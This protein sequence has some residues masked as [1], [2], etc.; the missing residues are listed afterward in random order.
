MSIKSQNMKEFIGTKGRISLVLQEM[1]SG[2]REEG[3]LIT[4]YNSEKGEYK[5]INNDSQYKDMYG[6][7]CT[8]IDMIEND[9]EG[10]P[11]I[12]SVFS[13]FKI[14]CL[15]QQGIMENRIIKID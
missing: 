11:T 13:A 14:A 7:V 8:L 12:D 10:N 9:T 3:D 5:I 2:D 4:L 6:Q 1:R 15:A